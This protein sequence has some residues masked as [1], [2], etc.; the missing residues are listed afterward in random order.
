MR[1]AILFVCLI[2][3]CFGSFCGESS[4]PFSFEVL[5]NGLPVVGCARPSCFGWKPDGTPVSKNAIFYKTDGY[6]DGYM[7][8]SVIPFDGDSHSFVP[9]VAQCE[10]SFDS[11]SCD[12]ENEWVGGIAAATFDASHS[13]MMALRCCTYGRLGLSSDRGTATLTNKQVTIGGEVFY[14][15]RQYGFDYIADVK[16]H[17]ATNGSIFYDVQMRRM[18]CLPPPREQTLNVDTEVKE[19]VRELLS[20]AIA[21]QKKK[22]KY[23][24][25]FAFQAP[26]VS[27]GSDNKPSIQTITKVTDT[28]DARSEISSHKNVFDDSQAIPGSNNEQPFMGAFGAQSDGGFVDQGLASRV[29]PPPRIVG[30]HQGQPVYESSGVGFGGFF[31]FSGD[32]I[33]ERSDGRMVRMDK[34]KLSDWILSV[35][36]G[37]VVYTTLVKWIH[38]VPQQIALFVKLFLEDGSV[39]KLTTRHYIYRT[40]CT[41]MQKYKSP[42]I[43][44]HIGLFI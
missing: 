8:E 39:L 44:E 19:Y 5:S 16:K 23:A 10:D 38:R 13:T 33:V 4:I 11:R 31:C 12:V 15:D 28:Q 32:T 25:T 34:L 22:A 26:L 43:I 20:A 41:D 21:L 40:Q 35:K 18:N 9:E 27:G 14:K 1:C 24:R 2:P 29:G 3:N 36:D 30:V 7:R 42:K 6:A 37:K 17:R